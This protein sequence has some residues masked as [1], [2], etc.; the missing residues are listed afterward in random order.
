MDVLLKPSFLDRISCLSGAWNNKTLPVQPLVLFEHT[1]HLADIQ[2]E[3]PDWSILITEYVKP[4]WFTQRS[5]VIATIGN[6]TNKQKQNVKKYFKKNIIDI[7]WETEIILCLDQVVPLSSWR[8]VSHFS[9]VCVCES[10]LRDCCFMLSA[11][12]WTSS[13]QVS[14]NTY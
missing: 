10:A 12:T 5:R 9:V 11:S 3:S 13:L 14:G 2:V 7:C 8:S 1:R 4:L 6:T